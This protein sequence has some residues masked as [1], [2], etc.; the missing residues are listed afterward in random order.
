MKTA[1]C[2]NDSYFCRFSTSKEMPQANHTNSRSPSHNFFSGSSQFNPS[3]G[4]YCSPRTPHPST[5]IQ[6]DRSR[7][8]LSQDFG[9]PGSNRSMSPE[10]DY[11]F[12]H[13][14]SSAQFSDEI[15]RSRYNGYIH[16]RYNARLK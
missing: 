8:P 7:S 12:D 14:P 16:K 2:I 9:K 5:L 15:Y 10:H 6:R 4:S 3:R 11:P 13:S 1:L